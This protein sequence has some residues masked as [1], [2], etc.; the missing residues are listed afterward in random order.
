MFLKF[1]QK[2]SSIY[3]SK[4]SNIYFSQNFEICISRR[5]F[6]YIVHIFF[7]TCLIMKILHLLFLI[8]RIFQNIFFHNIL[9][10]TC[11]QGSKKEW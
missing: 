9:E 8:Y 3:F 5:L 11:R 1:V 10:S 6:K 4:D 2:E 7:E